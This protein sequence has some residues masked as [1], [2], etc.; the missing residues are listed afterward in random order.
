M[1]NGSSLDANYQVQHKIGLHVENTGFHRFSITAPEE[2]TFGQVRRCVDLKSHEARA[3]KTVPKTNAE[4]RKIVLNEIQIMKEVAGKHANI[5][6]YIE[7]FEQ[8]SHFDLVFEWCDRGTLEDSAKNGNLSMNS[9]ASYFAKLLDALAF[10]KQVGILHRDVKPSNILLT[11]EQKDA[12]VNCRLGDFGS[13][14]KHDAAQ[15]L[16]EAAGTPGYFA[17]EELI[18]PKGYGY[19]FPV[20][21]WGAGVTLYMMLFKGVHPFLSGDYV[22]SQLVMEADYKVGWMNISSSSAVSLL[23]WLLLLAHGRGLM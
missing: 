23:S 21:I 7:H 5:L 12:S 3:V 14:C 1:G 17:P 11:T 15:P 4:R 20:D 16:F 19:S 2:G 9:A 10:L 18:L 6:R 22:Q 13:A 8:S